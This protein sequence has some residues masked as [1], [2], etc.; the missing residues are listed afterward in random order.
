MPTNIAAGKMV[1]RGDGR[2]RA[3]FPFLVHLLLL[4]VFLLHA[5]EAHR[6]PIPSANLQHNTGDHI[7]SVRRITRGFGVGGHG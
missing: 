7:S 2:R 3:L 4:C 5:T 1:A 6:S